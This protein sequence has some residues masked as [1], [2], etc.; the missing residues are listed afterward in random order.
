[1]AGTHR[2][3]SISAVPLPLFGGVL[4]PAPLFGLLPVPVDPSGRVDLTFPWPALPVG[5]PLVLQAGILDRAAVGGV[6][7]SNALLGP[8][9]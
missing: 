1:M 5:V 4:H 2:H 9:Q 7:L 3:P 6:A 8:T